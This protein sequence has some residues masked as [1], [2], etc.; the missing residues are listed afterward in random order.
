MYLH[1]KT[2]FL[3]VDTLERAL[4]LQKQWPK[5]GLT[6]VEDPRVADLL[7]EVDRPLFTYV[8]TFV[9]SDKKTSIVLGSGKQTA[10]DGTLASGGLA[11]DIVT[12][13]AQARLPQPPKK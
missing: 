1:S 9:L 7:I 3:T 5:L 11:K 6:L 13:F 8:H 2:S 10:F 12:I 4:L